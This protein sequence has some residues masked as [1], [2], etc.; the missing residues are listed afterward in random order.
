M[1]LMCVCVSLIYLT[2]KVNSVSFTHRNTPAA[3]NLFSKTNC[4]LK[5]LETE[6]FDSNMRISDNVPALT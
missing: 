5:I 2:V 3:E 4:T 6:T 1:L